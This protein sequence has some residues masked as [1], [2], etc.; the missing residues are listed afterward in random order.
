MYHFSTS[1][2]VLNLVA[3]HSHDNL[4]PPPHTDA[5]SSEIRKTLYKYFF[6]G[7]KKGVY[8]WL[9]FNRSKGCCHRGGLQR[10]YHDWLCHRIP[11]ER[12]KGT[13]CRHD[14]LF[15]REEKR[16]Q[17]DVEAMDAHTELSFH[18]KRYVSY[19]R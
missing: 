5:N 4:N 2:S 11:Q 18:K 17:K 8:M 7:R 10:G 19:V 14:T 3:R 15:C 1:I 16:Y 12:R 9:Q 6:K 13:E